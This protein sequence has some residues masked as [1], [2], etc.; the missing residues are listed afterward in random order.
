MARIA[1]KSTQRTI[2]RVVSWA[3][4]IICIAVLVPVQCKMIARALN[5]FLDGVP[6]D[7]SHR[8]VLANQPIPLNP[9]DLVMHLWLLL[10]G[11]VE[12]LVFGR[13]AGLAWRDRPFPFF[14]D[15]FLSGWRYCISIA[16]III[17]VYIEHEWVT[18]DES[19]TRRLLRE[20]GRAPKPTLME[21]LEQEQ[22]KENERLEQER[23]ERERLERERLERESGGEHHETANRTA[24]DLQTQPVRRASE[25]EESHPVR[26][27]AS[28][29]AFEDPRT[30]RSNDLSSNSGNINF[31]SQ[32]INRAPPLRDSPILFHA[33]N[34]L[35]TNSLEDVNQPGPSS[36]SQLRSIA[37]IQ[38][39]TSL[40]DDVRAMRYLADREPTDHS[41]A[42]DNFF[43]QNC[44]DEDESIPLQNESLLAMAA[45]LEAEAAGQVPRAPPL[46]N[47]LAA[48]D[49]PF[50]DIDAF[51]DEDDGGFL[52]ALFRLRWD[53]GWKVPVLYMC[54][55]DVICMTVL[56]F[57]YF[58]PQLIGRI[59]GRFLGLAIVLAGGVSRKFGAHVGTAALS[60][61][62]RYCGVFGSALFGL[63]E[64]YD[65]ARVSFTD[66]H[67]PLLNTV[68]FIFHFGAQTVMDVLFGSSSPYPSLTQ[69]LLTISLGY[70]IIFT[71]FYRTM[72]SIA[73]EKPVLGTKRRVYSY[74]FEVVSTAKVLF[75]FTI[76]AFLFP[77]FC[78]WLLDLCFV[79]LIVNRIEQNSMYVLMFTAHFGALLLSYVRTALYW[80]MGTGYMYQLAIFVGMARSRILR[81]GVLFFIRLPDDPNARLIHD[82]FV[83]PFRWQLLRIYLSAK[84]YTLFI[85]GGLGTVVWG[86]RYLTDG[87]SDK[88]VG[89]FPLQFS[90]NTIVRCFILF[91]AEVAYLQNYKVLAENTF[92]Y[93]NKAFALCAHRLRLSHFLLGVPIAQE[94]G[95]VVYRSVWQQLLLAEPDYSRPMSAREAA[96]VFAADASVNAC[97]VPD[98]LY[99]RAP[100]SNT[101]SRES[102]KR[103]FVAVT[104]DDELLE[105][106]PEVE[107]T[108][109]SDDEAEEDTGET[110][111]V[112]VYRPPYLMARCVGFGLLIW[113]FGVI[114]GLSVGVI[115]AMLGRPVVMAV[116]NVFGGEFDGRRLD[117]ESVA[118]GLLL[119]IIGVLAWEKH[120]KNSARQGRRVVRDA[121]GANGDDNP[122]VAEVNIPNE[123]Q[124]AVPEFHL[125]AHIPSIFMSLLWFISVLVCTNLL[126]IQIEGL[127]LSE[128][129]LGIVESIVGHGMLPLTVVY[130]LL[131]AVVYGKLP[132]VEWKIASL[133]GILA[134]VAAV[135]WAMLIKLWY[136]PTVGLGLFLV[137]EVMR[138]GVGVYASWT[139]KVKDEVYSRGRSLMSIEE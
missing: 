92:H 24:D 19:Y 51:D 56:V 77:V 88:D 123:V 71:T 120:S 13:A 132:S 21:M 68:S 3:L 104:K 30:S 66:G 36:A 42:I 54:L 61:V 80:A 27:N 85:V 17:A 52:D 130:P 58:V 37:S 115:S 10:L 139:Q 126:S 124:Q 101:N 105:P 122:V 100:A 48:D 109:H 73:R 72:V 96:A 90:L 82:A 22:K 127:G 47:D 4:A 93:W 34:I 137:M 133:W 50:N 20:V 113:V 97:F 112:V 39:D 98:G 121:D 87:T 49:V 91:L 59:G 44:L 28:E 60:H 14:T 12:Y 89:F 31:G 62:L 86:V 63:S 136:A 110:G 75:I 84:F 16:V 5:T 65:A 67:S 114:F 29:G 76:E 7:I 64:W 41:A 131:H 38:E 83:L 74:L 125:R 103:M 35:G 116:Y 119:S 81:P 23:L 107:P 25:H 9:V 106:M 118:I 11:Y 46:E 32:N 99:V 45:L 117:L 94:R 111:H 15:T 79:P 135:M 78:G 18:A 138:L 108:G 26:G 8:V 95:H 55:A 69:R 43:E 40:H 53:F 128:R 2:S 134:M 129:T 6:D 70:V 33:E 57:L 102:F 1:W